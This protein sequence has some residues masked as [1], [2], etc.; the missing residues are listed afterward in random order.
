MSD[1][2]TNNLGILGQPKTQ[3]FPTLL[4][5]LYILF[6]IGFRIGPPQ[7]HRRFRIGLR[8]IHRRFRI[9]P[10]K[11]HRRFRIGSPPATLNLLPSEFHSRSILVYHGYYARKA[12]KLPIWNR[13][14]KLGGQGKGEKR[15]RVRESMWVIRGRFSNVWKEGVARERES[16][17]EVGREE[18]RD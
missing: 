9:G 12:S 5:R 7:M 11:I 10:P 8:K 16:D 17:K 18:V 1:Q 15:R 6:L 2:P 13:M 14:S 4:L 3:S